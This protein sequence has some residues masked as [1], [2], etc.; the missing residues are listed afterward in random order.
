MKKIILSIFVLSLISVNS[1]A[2]YHG[3][4][5]ENHGEDEGRYG[6]RGEIRDFI[7]GK[8][9]RRLE[10]RLQSGEPAKMRP[11]LKSRG[12]HNDKMQ[13][14]RRKLD[15]LPEAKRKEAHEEMKRHHQKI[16]EIIGEEIPFPK[17]GGG[18]KREKKREHKAVKKPA[19]GLVD[20]KNPVDIA[21]KVKHP[22]SDSSSQ[23]VAPL[24]EV[25]AGQ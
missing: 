14:I 20:R 4:D 1:Y 16:S 5:R 8:N 13:D 23:R 9:H 7:P 17:Y 21:K 6:Q 19:E 11:H 2:D 10:Y 12:R 24:P 18:K 3:G 15:K 22:R 25:E